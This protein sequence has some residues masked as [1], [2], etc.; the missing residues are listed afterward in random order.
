MICEGAFS[1]CSSLSEII[2]PEGAVA[3]E[4]YAFSGCGSL[5]SVSAPDSMKYIGSLVFED[6]NELYHMNL[7]DSITSPVQFTEEELLIL[8]GL[9][10]PYSPDAGETEAGD[11]TEAEAETESEQRM[12]D[13]IDVAGDQPVYDEFDESI[14]EGPGIQEDTFKGC[15]D[16]TLTVGEESYGKQYAI[17]HGFDYNYPD[18]NDWL[19]M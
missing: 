19:N 8:K 13:M 11:E 17:T 15:E 5:H 12:E 4:D 16:L 3:I 10:D 9:Y 6:C 1:D 2:I 18:S 14:L 7:S